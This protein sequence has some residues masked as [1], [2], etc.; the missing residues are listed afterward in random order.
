MSA[1]FTHPTPA[2]RSAIA[3][4]VVERTHTFLSQSELT[5]P[6]VEPLTIEEARIIRARVWSLFAEAA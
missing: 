6:G 4:R 3:Q 2:S 1:T 5:L